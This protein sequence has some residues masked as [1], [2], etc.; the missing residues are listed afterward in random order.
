MGGR[1]WVKAILDTLI[2]DPYHSVSLPDVTP[3]RVVMSSN[4]IEGHEERIKAHRK[5][6]ELEMERLGRVGFGS[7]F[8]ICECGEE[9]V[10]R[11][12]DGWKKVN[13]RWLCGSCVVGRDSQD[14]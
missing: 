6:I 12:E 2:I 11:V 13:G 3:G 8:L 7:S 4:R 10:H 5:R 1:T 9:T 14:V